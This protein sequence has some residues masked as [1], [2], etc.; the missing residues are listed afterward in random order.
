MKRTA[1]GKAMSQAGV[2]TPVSAIRGADR[3]TLEIVPAEAA[4]KSRD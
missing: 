3:L 2:R 1:S 4:D